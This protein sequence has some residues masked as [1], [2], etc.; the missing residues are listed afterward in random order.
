MPLFVAGVTLTNS[1]GLRLAICVCVCDRLEESVV[2][3]HNCNK[4][5]SHIYIEREVEKKP[6]H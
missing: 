6:N 2:P 1:L 4:D 5:Q 3:E